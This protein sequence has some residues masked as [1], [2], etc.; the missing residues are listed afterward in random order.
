MPLQPL[1]PL[2]HT[3]TEKHTHTHTHIDRETHTLTHTHKD[4]SSHPHTKKPDTQVSIKN[5]VADI[6]VN[7]LGQGKNK[8][9]GNTRKIS[10]LKLR[11]ATL[12]LKWALKI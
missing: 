2:K 6:F 12:N 4:K 11:I 8:D 5:I 7:P 1:Y 3:Q 9:I 10:Y